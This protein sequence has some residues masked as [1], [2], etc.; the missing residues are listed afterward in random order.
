MTGMLL[1][2]GQASGQLLQRLLSGP[3]G[4]QHAWVGWVRVLTVLSTR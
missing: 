3:L 4:G 1:V 2:E